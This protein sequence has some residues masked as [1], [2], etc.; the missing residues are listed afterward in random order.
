MNSTPTEIAIIQK[1]I[2]V[3]EIEYEAIKKEE[4]INFKKRVKE[5]TKELKNLKSSEKT[6]LEK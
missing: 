4:G 2:R 6:L 3:L 5:I 1:K